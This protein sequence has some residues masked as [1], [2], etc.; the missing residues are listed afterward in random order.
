MTVDPYFSTTR[1]SFPV[2]M[3]LIDTDYCFMSTDVG[4]YGASSDC[5]IFKNSNFCKKLERNHLNILGS[6]LLPNDDNGTPMPFIVGDE[7]SALLQHVL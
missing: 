7:A 4:A 3:A 1:T 2:L 5:N 6:R